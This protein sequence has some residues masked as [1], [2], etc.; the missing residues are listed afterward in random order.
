MAG[1]RRR[2]VILDLD[3]DALPEAP[4]PADAPPVETPEAAAGEKALALAR[5]RGGLS[6][7]GRLFWG[8]LAGIVTLGIALWLDGFLRALFARQ[9]WLGWL[10]VG[11]VAVLA[12]AVLG[13]A[14]R[15]LAGL[16]RLERI[17][18]FRREARAAE[19][20]DTGAAGSVLAGLGKLYA[21]RPE[22]ERASQR[23]ADAAAETPDAAARLE[24][25]E[26]IWMKPL[27]AEAERVIARTARD[28]AGATA[29][30]PMALIDILA[31]LYLNLRM[32]RRIAE[33]YGGRAGWLGS[34]RL[35]RAVAMHLAATGAIAAGDD[36]LGPLVGTGVL[37]R[38][39][40]RFGEATVNAALSVRVGVATA[41]VCRPLPFSA[42]PSPRARSVLTRALKDWQ[43]RSVPD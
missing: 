37:A 21:G 29:M 43:D 25:A 31:V 4:S 11:L 23:M 18:R 36:I 22:L 9:D 32:I 40:R 14:L 42:L 30:I 33:I 5:R 6:A 8:A 38:L 24:L 1:K 3:R 41:E 2:P 28:V 34:W 15:E 12:A 35:L 17:E 7:L 10:G 16:A 13:L 20:G 26:R 27:D 19:G 39:S